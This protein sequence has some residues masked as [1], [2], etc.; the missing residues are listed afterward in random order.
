MKSIFFKLASNS[1]AVSSQQCSVIMATLYFSWMGIRNNNFFQDH[2]KLECVMFKE[3]ISWNVTRTQVLELGPRDWI[4]NCALMVIIWKKWKPR[5]RWHSA[6][7]ALVMLLK[8]GI[9]LLMM[10]LR[11]TYDALIMHLWC[12]DDALMMRWWCADD[13]LMMRWWCTDDAL[14][15]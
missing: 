10:H 12:N 9:H 3:A 4:K 2:H 15:M 11:C 13:A 1:A 5:M 6:N 14:M 8:C 7:D